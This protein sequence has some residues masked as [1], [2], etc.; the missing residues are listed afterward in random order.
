MSMSLPLLSRLA[1]DSKYEIEDV[2]I[3][4]TDGP[5]KDTFFYVQT[6]PL[7][8]KVFLDEK[9]LITYIGREILISPTGEVSIVANEIHEDEE[10]IAWL[11][12]LESTLSSHKEK[13]KASADSKDFFK[14]T[15][16]P[17][18][19]LGIGKHTLGIEA[20]GGWAIISPGN[21]AIH[22]KSATIPE[23]VETTVDP[24]LYEDV[25]TE[26]EPDA[27]RKPL[28]KQIKLDPEVEALSQLVASLPRAHGTPALNLTEQLY[29]TADSTKPR[30]VRGAE[31][32]IQLAGAMF[33]NG[34]LDRVD[35][36]WSV[37][38]LN[39]QEGIVSDIDLIL[40]FDDE[41]WIVDAKNIMGKGMLRTELDGRAGWWEHEDAPER[42]QHAFRMS[43]NM[44][45][46]YDR[47]TAALPKVQIRG[48]V[49]F[50]ERP[51]D[52]F[53]ERTIPA[54]LRWANDKRVPIME[55]KGFIN[56]LQEKVQNREAIRVGPQK[57]NQRLLSIITGDDPDKY[58]R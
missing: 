24:E 31:G 55:Q 56:L 21:P 16:A 43:R 57:M 7:K 32:E 27:K 41:L 39:A 4:T 17:G 38:M 12:L 9:I 1:I 48:F 25:E 50:V 6:G 54:G 34:I 26:E 49:V 33:E 53:N 15:I 23:L 18:L 51:E 13:E 28:F 14:V 3:K 11:E 46:A 40:D 47:Y 58:S 45:Y 20:H 19:T 30:I 52:V 36:Y 29:R 35:S 5:E 42:V 10:E 37:P 2:T 22:T 44:S 8:L